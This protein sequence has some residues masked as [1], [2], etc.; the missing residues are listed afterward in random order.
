M[1]RQ[2]STVHKNNKGFTLVELMIVVAI[3]GILAAI[4]IPQYMAY[5]DRTK[6]VAASAA[7]TS[8]IN[9][10]R[11]EITKVQGDPQTWVF[12]NLI[13][14]NTTYAAYSTA[15]APRAAAAQVTYLITQALGGKAD[16]NP[17]NP[18]QT[19]YTNGATAANA[20][21]TGIRYV[22]VALPVPAHFLIDALNDAGVAVTFGNKA[23]DGTP[24]TSVMINAGT[25]DLMAQ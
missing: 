19:L 24:A 2:L 10:T 17:L 6:K 15:A 1:M 4:A 23:S 3:I 12:P 22:A 8:L 14:T 9:S 7:T 11:G 13:D 21:Q 5:I 16:K 25:G 18:A 20:G